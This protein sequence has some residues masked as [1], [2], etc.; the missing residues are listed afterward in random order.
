MKAQKK[1]GC[2]TPGLFGIFGIKLAF[3]FTVLGSALAYLVAWIAL[4]NHVDSATSFDDLAI[5][6]AVLQRANATDNF[7]RIDLAGR[8]V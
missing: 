6:M 5:G 3:A 1:P 7:H 2:I 4:A 8:I